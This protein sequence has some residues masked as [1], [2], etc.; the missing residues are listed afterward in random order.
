VKLSAAAA[1]AAAA[2]LGAIG[3]PSRIIADPTDLIAL[4]VLPR[5]FS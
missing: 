4:A 1:G 2:A 5:P 3:I